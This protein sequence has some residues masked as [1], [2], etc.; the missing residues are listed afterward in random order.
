[1]KQCVPDAVFGK[2]AEQANK[3]NEEENEE[4]AS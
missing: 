3:E 2:L 4:E 1:M